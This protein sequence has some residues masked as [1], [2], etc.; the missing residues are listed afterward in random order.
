MYGAS[1][2]TVSSLAAAR[3][4][5]WIRTPSETAAGSRAR[6]LSVTLWTVWVTAS[7]KV[8]EPGTAVNFTVV[9]VPKTFPPLVRSR[10]TS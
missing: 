4:G 10:L 6:P 8:E 9:V 2:T 7:M 1:A 3:S 5:S